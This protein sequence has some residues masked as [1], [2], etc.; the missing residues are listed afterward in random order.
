MISKVLLYSTGFPGSSDGKEAACKEGDQGL[1]PGSGRSPGEGN[2]NPFQYSCLENS[3]E[4]GAWCAIVD[5]VTKKWT[6][7]SNYSA[8]SYVAAW[9]GEVFGGESI[10]IFVCLSPFAIHLKISQHC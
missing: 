3:K 2:G 9:M 5:R 1:V 6:Q 4:R 10:H 8:Q 7:L